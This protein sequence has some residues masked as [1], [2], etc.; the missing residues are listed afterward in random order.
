MNATTSVLIRI[1]L[2]VVVG[3]FCA[4]ASYADDV[5]INPKYPITGH[6]GPALSP[7]H[8]GATNECA[9]HVYVDSFVPKATVRIFLNGTTLIGGPVAPKYGFF[10]FPVSQ[11]LHTGDKIM[12]TQT[13][14][15]VTSAP[16]QPMIVGSMP[17]TLA[18]PDVGKAIYACGRVAPVTGLV[19]GVTIEVRDETVGTTIGNGFTPNDW[20]DDWAPVLT[21]SLTNGHNIVARQHACTGVTSPF[22]AAQ[23]VNP[24]PSPITVPSL[25]P[26]VVGNDTITAHHLLTG[27]EVKAFDHAVGIGAGYATGETN[28]MSVAPNISATS[29]ISAEQVLCGASGQSPPETPVSRL[30]PPK[31]VAPICPG[32]HAVT[33]RDSTMNATLVLLKNGVVVGYG[34]AGPGDVPLDIAP[35]ASFAENDTVEVVEYLGGIL[36]TS[37][38]V[39]VGCQDVIT[40]HNDSQR[41]GWNPH[42]NT[43]TPA[44]VNASDFGLIAKTELD[45]VNDQVEAQPLIVTNQTIEG[46]GVHAVAYVVTQNNSVYAI[47]AFDGAKLHKVNLGTAVP[48]PLNCENNGAVVG[49]NST[50]TI[51]LKSRT[52]YVIAYVMVGSTPTHRLHAL[53][54]ATLKDKPGSPVTVAATNT[55][56]DGSTHHF[57]SSV[58]R[59]RPA[60]LQANGNIYAG[61]GAYC[62]FQASL[63]RGW[64]LGWEQSSLKSLANSELL[65]KAVTG[66]S[67]FDCY[68]HTP[69]TSN[70]PCFLSSVW[71][72]GYGL[73]SDEEGSLFF[74]TGNTA[75]GIYD[76]TTNLAESVVKLSP[77]LSKVLDFFTPADESALDSAD[78]DYG[79]GGALVLPKQPGP[80]PHI[81][82]AAGKKGDLFIVNRDTGQMGGFKNPNVPASVPIDE[83]WCGPAYFKGADNVGRVV[84]SGGHQVKQWTVN[85]AN[86]PALALEASAPPMQQSGQDGGFFTSVSSNGTTAKTAIIWA[87]N[88]PFGLNHV[89]TLYAF[90]ATAAGGALKQLWSDEGGTWPNTSGNS[91]MVPTVANGMVYVASYKQLRIF[92][93]TP[94]KAAPKRMLVVA[95]HPPPPPAPLAQLTAATGPLYWGTIRAVNGSRVT[96]ELRNGRTLPV[97]VSKVLPQATSDFG[98]VGRALAVSGT[99]GPDGVLAASSILRAKGPSLWGPDREQ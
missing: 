8:V 21:S 73:A 66:P 36:T 80:K 34:G 46:K 95:S 58:Q 54:L 81:T 40:Y 55:L 82:I 79:S 70:H 75:P 64:V 48:R 37:N 6:G 86:T 90:D 51:D 67:N 65:D 88:R 15:G 25:D 16:S 59:Q 50:P 74:T 41:T 12:A 27:S 93:L 77:D 57:D 19:S 17:A 38:T 49:I 32:Q 45:D 39:K 3:S 33:V 14:N 22:S 62:D 72:S 7:P 9:T 11:A 91:N 31:L 60:L 99:V 69:W 61:F 2:A 56:K 53:D 10:A 44:N 89:L 42:E 1:S 43:L 71:M 78:N 85:T 98:A 97:D 18:A 83:C 63:S 26:P 4:A 47:D 92:G 84:S 94:P 23:A 68:F 76:S 24:D 96:L 5:Y 28:W 87:V 35:I 29:S 52:L 13:V 30:N 20:G